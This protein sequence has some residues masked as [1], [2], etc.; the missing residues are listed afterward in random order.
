M[1]HSTRAFILK[2]FPQN[3]HTLPETM[4]LSLSPSRNWD[5]KQIPVLYKTLPSAH[6][7][8]LNNVTPHKHLSL[9]S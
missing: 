3:N 1:N 2:R 5:I 4:C 7:G 6:Q 9:S 8:I